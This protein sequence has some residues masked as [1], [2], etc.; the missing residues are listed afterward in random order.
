MKIDEKLWTCTKFPLLFW[1]E[2]R[3]LSRENRGVRRV[4]RCVLQPENGKIGRAEWKRK[5]PPPKRGGA[6]PRQKNTH[7]YTPKGRQKKAALIMKTHPRFLNRAPRA[8][9]KTN[10]PRPTGGGRRSVPKSLAEFAAYRRQKSASPLSEN[11]PGFFDSLSA[12]SSWRR[13]CCRSTASWRS[14]AGRRRARRYTAGARRACRA[15]AARRK[16]RGCRAGA[17]A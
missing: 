5:P 7:K 6:R 11:P 2:K 16:R 17:G 10:P 8:A 12:R 13:W 4:I 14:R 3:M 15:S 1:A 9:T